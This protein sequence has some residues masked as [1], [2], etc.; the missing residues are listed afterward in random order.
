[1]NKEWPSREED[2]QDAKFIMNKHNDFEELSFNMLDITITRT[3]NQLKVKAPE[4]MVE[5]AQYFDEKYGDDLGRN[6][7]RKVITNLL[8]KN[9][10]IH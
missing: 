7:T 3:D 10:T 4:W 2:L 6:I 1:M 9:V 8:L 5:M